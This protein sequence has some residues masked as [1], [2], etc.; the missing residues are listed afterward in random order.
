MKDI[1]YFKYKNTYEYNTFLKDY[2]YKIDD[3]VGFSF[4]DKEQY[5]N[6]ILKTYN[7]YFKDGEYEYF[8][9]VYFNNL[10]E[11]HQSRLGFN[12]NKLLNWCEDANVVW[13]KVKDIYGMRDEYVITT[14]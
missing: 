10:N 14:K 9:V 3:V 12:G 4:N 6:N 7:I 13:Y 8:K 1:K 5:H 2:G 11:Y